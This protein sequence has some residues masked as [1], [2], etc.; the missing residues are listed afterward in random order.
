MCVG[1]QALKC[2][3]SGTSLAVQGL[4]LCTFTAGGTGLIPGR[5]IEI[6]HAKYVG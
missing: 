5:G 2:A 3:V 1:R 4:G 6:L